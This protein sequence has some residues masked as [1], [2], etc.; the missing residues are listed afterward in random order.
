MKK[1]L[2]LIVAL[3]S[4]APWLDAQVRIGRATSTPQ[5]AVSIY[6]APSTTRVSGALEIRS[7][8]ALNG[9]VAVLNG[10]VTV[11]GRVTGSLVA[12]N[13]DVR[14]L[15]GASIG[16]HVIIVGGT[17]TREEEVSVG[18]EVRTQAELLRYTLDGDRLVPEED[19]WM[20]WRPHWD[21][22][23]LEP[24]GESYTD[25][26]FVAASTYNR[27][28][29]LPVRVGPRFRRPTSWGRLE[30][31][32]FGVFRTAGPVKWD[33]GTVGHDARL[34][35]RLGVK[36]GL[37]LGWRAFDVIAPVESWQVTDTEAGLATFLLHRDVRDYYGRHGWETSLGGRMGEEASLSFVV[38]SERWRPVDARDPFTLFRDNQ[39]WRVNAPMDA[40]RVDMVTTRLRIDTR[41]RY[42]SPLLGGWYVSADLERGSGTITRATGP[43]PA[44]PE[45]PIT[46]TRGFI[47]ARRYNRLS[48][49]TQLNLRIV[50]GGWM[51]GDHLPLQR[52]LSMGGPGALDGYD[53]RRNWYDAEDVYTCGGIADWSG[54]PTLCQRAAI[55]QVEIRQALDFDWYEWDRGRWWQ[56][57]GDVTP[58]WVVYAEAGRG[59]PDPYSTG[60][61]LDSDAGMPPFSSFRTTVGI[62]IDFGS[63]GLY[64]AKAAG[65]SKES[66]NVI[67]RL[68][69]RF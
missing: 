4:A 66:A 37:V 39:D 34:G 14:L 53:F 7:D 54:R 40:G 33:R 6:N 28:E 51:G 11:S 12:I 23:G 36:N 45:G 44:T 43:D 42:R 49:G 20:E 18:G 29:G 38:G 60:L 1:S 46:Y 58:S 50:A 19:R 16:E 30:A 26:F 25:L 21:G 13:A 67:V 61:D 32:A 24:R 3:L 69:R 2:T 59:W 52:R 63:L 22:P 27:V 10:P 31:E 62:G 68:G 41:D 8:S 17:L 55:A 48:P 57:G 9:D 15:R 56:P 47:D 65:N 35:L 64:L 5:S